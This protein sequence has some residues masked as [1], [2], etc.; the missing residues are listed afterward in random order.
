MGFMLRQDVMVVVVDD[1]DDDVSPVQWLQ[2]VVSPS[3]LSLQHWTWP[4]TPAC[5]DTQQPDNDDDYDNDK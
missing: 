5:T 2:S 3:F 1:I 4:G